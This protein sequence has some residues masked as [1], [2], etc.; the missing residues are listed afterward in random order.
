MQIY[1]SAPA[2]LVDK[3]SE[4]LRAFGKTKDLAPGKRDTLKFTL[5]AK[6]LASFIDAQSAWIVEKGTYT[7]KVG[8]SSAAIKLMEN[9]SLEGNIT[10]EEVNDIFKLDNGM[11]V[12]KN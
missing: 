3:P 10:A 1:V 2:N 9:F 11:E 8:A 4:E 12:F 7:V 5:K 6:D